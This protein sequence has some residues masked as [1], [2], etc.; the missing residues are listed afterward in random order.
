MAHKKWMLWVLLGSLGA[1]A[2]LG[3]LAVLLGSEGVVAQF[4]GTAVATVLASLL[5]LWISKM[6]EK[7]RTRTAGWVG[8][9]GILVEYLLV[10]IA[11]WEL[12]RG[13]FG[14]RFEEALWL[15]VVNLGLSVAVA[16]FLLR[17]VRDA[18]HRVASR[19]GLWVCG[20]F[21][22]VWLTAAWLPW[23][24]S[25][26]PYYA[27]RNYE[28][29]SRL[30]ETAWLV[31]LAGVVVWASLVGHEV[32][33]GRG[34]RWGGVL[35]GLAALGVGLWRAW[36]IPVHGAG[37]D[38][39]FQGLC[40]LGGV[41]A[42]VGHANLVLRSSPRAGMRWLKPVTIVLA[43]LLAGTIDTAVVFDRVLDSN[44]E[45]SLARL[46]GAFGILTGSGSLALAVITGMHRAEAEQPYAGQIK[47]MTVVCPHC[48][49]KQVV[50]LGDGVCGD[51]GLRIH[52]QVQD[53]KCPMCEY[54][55]YKLQ[56]DHCP[57]CGAA[58]PWLVHRGRQAPAEG[59]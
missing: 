20:V 28:L 35:G 30:W 57:E 41:A 17:K 54:L 2:V 23:D 1:T 9:G 46:A 43:V 45:E 7:P 22:V 36:N 3:V 11:V 37:E 26:S 49:K 44:I 21:V 29:S 33:T 16:V 5:V 19:T 34:W 8:M 13:L 6:M 14:W 55:L 10:N 4:V 32:G 27:T 40:V 24:Y 51:C 42:V 58:I 15:T 25:G 38:V 31:F 50:G 47:A 52:I 56:S 12:G 59:V 18:D 48:Q 39:A 53:P